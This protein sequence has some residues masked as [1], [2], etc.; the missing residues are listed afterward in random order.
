M[1]QAKRARGN[2]M[3]KTDFKKTLKQFYA[4]SA[5]EFSIVEVPKMQFVMLDGEGNPNTSSFYGEAIGWVYSVSYA[6]KFA[7]KQQ[8]GRDY[9]VPPL[10]ALWWADDMMAFTAGRKDD[11]KWTEMI[12]TPDWITP[13][14]FEQAVKKSEAKLGSPPPSLRLEAYDEG[15]SVQIMHIGPYDA[16]GPVL[17]RLHEEFLPRNGLVETGH[18]HEIYLGD[19]RR[20][21]PEK[22]KTVLRQPVRR[23][24]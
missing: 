20:T 23:T 24:G 16:E 1:V 19:P 13:E 14:M 21:A 11:W 6:L 8:L 7:S 17:K 2:G 10:E 5:K 9:T 12:M 22:L 18:H 15:L 3:D 4:P